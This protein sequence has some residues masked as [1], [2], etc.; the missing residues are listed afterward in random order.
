MT[1]KLGTIGI[2]LDSTLNNLDEVWLARYNKDYDDN[3][4]REDMVVW[5]VETYVKPECGKKIYDYL[6]EPEFF[7]NLGI[8]HSAYGITK[9]LSKYFDLHIVTAYHPNTCVD[10]TN[11]IKEYLPHINSRNIIF[12]NNKGLIDTDYLIDDGHHN[13]IDFKNKGIVFDAKYNR[14]LGE[15]YTRAYDWLDIHDFFTKELVEV[16]GI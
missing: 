14:H 5:E 4:T 10:K 13:I 15:E 3:L 1:K 12:C 16:W 11:W 2:D 7:Y 9:W 8:Q 6:L